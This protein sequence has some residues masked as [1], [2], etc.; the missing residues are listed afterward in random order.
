MDHLVGSR[1]GLGVGGRKEAGRAGPDE[2]VLP[3][4]ARTNRSAPRPCRSP[5][6]NSPEYAPPPGH[7]RYSGRTRQST[8]RR[9]ATTGTLRAGREG[10]YHPQLPL[11]Q[12]DYRVFFDSSRSISAACLLSLGESREP[13]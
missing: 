2:P 4:G 8:R 13:I 6:K 1:P 12:Y 10:V 9:P 7:D 5:W 3:G 11:I